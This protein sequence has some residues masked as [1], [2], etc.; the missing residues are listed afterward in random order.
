MSES[1]FTEEGKDRRR[2]VLT[3]ADLK[4]IGVAVREHTKCNLGWTVEEVSE[5]KKH[6][7]TPDEVA[8]VKKHVGIF[9]EAASIIGKV[10]LTAIGMAF[11]A[12]IT[13]GWWASMA[14]GIQKSGGH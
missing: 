11:V 13:K 5:Y 7:L 9:N 14:T 3:E 6:G 1:T 8:V 4:A 12:L 10:I 2:S